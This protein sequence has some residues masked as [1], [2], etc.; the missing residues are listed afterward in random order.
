MPDG[1]H[2]YGKFA[3][4]EIVAPERLV[5]V[6]SFSDA[7]GNTIRAPFSELFSLKIYNTLTLFDHEGRTTL[8]MRG[9]PFVGR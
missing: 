6:D 3:Y 4:Q 2:I 9:V 1:N 5:F 8:T 7:D